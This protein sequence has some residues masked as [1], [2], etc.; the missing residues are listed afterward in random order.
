MGFFGG[1]LKNTCGSAGIMVAAA[2]VPLMLSAGIAIDV[3]RMSQTRTVLQAAADAAAIA[4]ATSKN[5]SDANLDKV[6]KDYLKANGADAVLTQVNAMSQWTDTS[7]ATFNVKIEGALNTSLMKLAGIS[8]MD[9]SVD[10]QVNLG[11]QSLEL[12]LV[13]DNT[14]SMSGVK[15]QS[16]K[17]AA[18]E[19]VRIIKSAKSDYATLKVALVP[20]SEY[21]NVG[22]ANAAASWVTFASP[23]PGWEGCVGSRDNPLDETAGFYVSKEYPAVAAA[24]CITPIQPL[25]SDISTIN[26]RIDAMTAE[27]NTYVP[28]GLLW[29]WNV[30]SSDAPFSEGMTETQLKEKNGLKVIVLMTDGT[31]TLSPAYPDHVVGNIALSDNKLRDICR[32]VKDEKYT[33]YTVSFM[34]EDANIVQLMKNCASVHE[35]AFDADNPAELYTSFQN[36]GE[37]LAAVR[38][39]Q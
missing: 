31:N 22:P 35:N 37:S 11:Q 13:L 25:T 16:L 21:V 4:G 34:I 1:F 2:A 24:R 27:G 3:V 36:I 17:A 14:G 39:T 6:V 19:L 20:F 15:I 23:I 10:S 32:N 18:K 26:S 28:G 38:I 9:I 29:G 8:S 5:L 7:N 33:I 12:A 30:L